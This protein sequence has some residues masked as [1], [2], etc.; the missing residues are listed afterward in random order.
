MRYARPHNLKR[1]HDL[2]SYLE[3]SCITVGEDVLLR[4]RHIQFHEQLD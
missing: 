2:D 3:Q 4:T 1:Y